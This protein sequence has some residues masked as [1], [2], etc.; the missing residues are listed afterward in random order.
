MKVIKTL[1]GWEFIPEVKKEEKKLKN[2][3]IGN[4]S[5]LTNSHQATCLPF[6]VQN[7]NKVLKG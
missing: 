2:M 1:Y 4:K 3:V 6:L 5:R 7:Q